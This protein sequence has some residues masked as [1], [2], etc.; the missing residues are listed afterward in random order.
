M[1]KKISL[2]NLV[3]WSIVIF[4]IMTVGMLAAVKWDQAMNAGQYLNVP[5]VLFAVLAT[6]GIDG[7]FITHS[8]SLLRDAQVNN[9]WALGWGI[10]CILFMCW[11]NNYVSVAEIADSVRA[12]RYMLIGSI[13][14][15]ASAFRFVLTLTG[16]GKAYDD[17]I[18]DEIRNKYNKSGAF[19]N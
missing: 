14:I 15:A 13:S 8:L 12:N 4:T 11:A 5:G 10:A 7:L 18:F 2:S 3:P 9:R 19:Q 16:Q 6:F 1:K 17:G